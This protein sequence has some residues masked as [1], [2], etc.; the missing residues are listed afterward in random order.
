VTRVA[1]TG[2]TGFV[3]AALIDLL[4][5]E[6]HEVSVLARNPQR[7][8]RTN[9]VR[10]VAGDLQDDGALR[11]IAENADAMIHL[12]GVTH[13][14]DE[15]EYVRVNIDGAQRAAVA[16]AAANT[17]F[18]HASS[19]SARQPE[20][21]PYARSKFDS[22]TRVREASA[23][24]QWA[25][26]RLPAI[27]GPGDRATL[28]FFKLVNAGVAPEPATPAPA[29]AS[30]LFVEDAAAALL[31]AVNGDLDSGVYEV[32]DER[33]DGYAWSEIGQILGRALGKRPAGMRVP[34]PVIAALHG[35]TRAA[36]RAFHKPSSVRVGQVNEF[37][38][39]DWVARDNLFNTAAGWTPKTPLDEGFA[40]TVRWYQEQGLL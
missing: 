12:A 5:R 14:R 37:F 1:V 18:V 30:I 38:H 26:L 35:V 19:M 24:N 15:S 4:L 36:E 25:A 2:G 28:P 3:G 40:K 33:G 32:G 21:S 23:A 11:A 7:V 22:E 20:T 6:N 8:R 39:P 27:Y 13:A 16:A 17:K 9:D 29:R 34:R 10:I 31:A